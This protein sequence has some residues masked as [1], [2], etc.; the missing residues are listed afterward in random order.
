[1]VC[2]YHSQFLL[3]FQLCCLHSHCFLEAVC[4][5]GDLTNKPSFAPCRVQKRIWDTFCPCP[6]S[7][8]FPPRGKKPPPSRPSHRAGEVEKNRAAAAAAGPSLSS[9]RN[10]CVTLSEKSRVPPSPAAFLCSSS[11]NNGAQ[12]SKQLFS[13]AERPSLPRHVQAAVLLLQGAAW[14]A[15]RK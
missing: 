9:I 7:A 11:G 13:L 6:K 5:P 14:E 4:F 15:M 3:L 10:C 12:E 1:M 8:V 2:S